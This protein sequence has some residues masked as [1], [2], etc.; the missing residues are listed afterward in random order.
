MDLSIVIP[1]FNEAE[2]IAILIDKIKEIFRDL[3][4]E[5]EI[6]IVD[7]GSKDNT[8]QIAKEK[9]T[10]AFIQQSPGYGGALKDAINLANGQ[11]II[12]LDADLS[13]NPY[14]IKR[15]FFH[16]L[17]GHVVIASRYIRGGIAD[18]P[19]LRHILSVILNKALG[20]SLSLPIKDIS[21]GFRLYHAK[22]FKEIDFSERDFNVL[23][24][25]LVKAYMNGFSVREVPFHYQ[26]RTK[27][28]SHAKIFK[29]GLGYLR[30]FLKLWKIRNAI[31][32]ADYDEL[33][34]YSRI[35]FQRYWQRKRYRI[36][37]NFTGWSSRVLN[38]GCRT[39]KIL[40]AL[41]QAVGL[42]INFKK[43][44]YN[45][46]LGN[47]LVNAEIGALCFKDAVFDKV[48]CSDVIG[49]LEKE[50]RIFLE[51]RRVLKK[52]GILITGT[53]DYARLPWRLI[54]WLY[55][56]LIPGSYAGKYISHYSRKDLIQKMLGLGFQLESYSYIL[57]SEL[58]C[59]FR[60]IL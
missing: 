20:F 22:I 37:L 35:P 32:S 19:I 8:F 27:G 26:P 31:S 58:I 15:L 1:T 21:S 39:S 48:I 2:N 55:K 59:K 41:P 49:Y 13:H 56:K 43:L 17:T 60:K 9:E 46:C 3:D 25:I 24:E 14:I 40:G 42:D 12:T 10:K 33:A 30:T 52:N 4:C 44:R 51:L 11:Y 5:Y 7:A 53:P 16:R 6:I 29:F 50:E 54:E 18:M 23:V 38:V 34:F 57:G 47:S 28:K 45:L 36:I